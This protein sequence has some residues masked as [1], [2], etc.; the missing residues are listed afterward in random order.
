MPTFQGYEISVDGSS[1]MWN[2]APSQHLFSN[3]PVATQPDA[4]NHDTPAT[5]MTLL[6]PNLDADHD[7][8]QYISLDQHTFRTR[9]ELVQPGCSHRPAPP[10]PELHPRP[11]PV[12]QQSE[13]TAH[14]QALYTPLGWQPESAS[15]PSYGAVVMNQVGAQQTHPA[16]QAPMLPLA[17]DAQAA[18]PQ[19]MNALVASFIPKRVQDQPRAAFIAEAPDYAYSISMDEPALHFTLVETLAITLKWFWNHQFALRF[20]NNGLT[21]AV[22]LAILQEHRHLPFSDAEAGRVKDN[23]SD[24]YRRTMRRY[25]EAWS[26]S[27]HK[28]PLD[29]DD[30]SLLVNGFIPDATKSPGWKTPDPVPFKDLYKGMKKLPAGEDAAD[31]TRALDFAMKNQKDGPNNEKQE[32]MFPDDL[33][34]ILGTIGYTT[35]TRNHCDTS[36]INR[37]KVLMKTQIAASSK[38]KLALEQAGMPTPPQKRRHTKKTKEPTKEA[39]THV[40]DG[41]DWDNTP[42]QAARPIMVPDEHSTLNADEG[43]D[44]EALPDAANVGWASPPA[45]QSSL[46]HAPDSK[47]PPATVDAGSINT[48][49]QA[50]PSL[51][52]LDSGHIH[53]QSQY[54]AVDDGAAFLPDGQGEMDA[55]LAQHQG[56][57]YS[58]I[59]YPQDVTDM[60]LA[61]QDDPLANLASIN[62][63]AHYPDTQL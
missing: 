21:S 57:D 15:I 12:F 39:Q 62:Q 45:Q 19:S 8:G 9:Q 34:T 31:L 42:Q 54:N 56:T 18:V 44:E 26:K 25:L 2:G 51:E 52:A 22:H 48:S 46:D 29:W 36:I 3:Q 27:T 47:L 50:Q 14:R 40:S 10:M 32:F 23:M 63:W 28:V 11:H 7:F 58:N 17:Q 4:S 59:L 13:H 1:R 61:D 6:P 20:M 41:S 16:M 5:H 37:Y 60:P 55:L 35:V 24:R 53:G 38:H 30:G 33:H 49:P 43:H